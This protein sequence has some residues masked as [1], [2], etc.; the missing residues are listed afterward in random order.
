VAARIREFVSGLR[1]RHPDVYKAARDYAEK[2]GIAVADLQAA[3]I[4][5]YLASDEEGKEVLES[6]MEERA[7]SGGGKGTDV[8][9][10]VDMFVKMSEGITKMFNA[11]NDM[12]NAVS[13]SA[14][15][16][17]IEAITTAVDKIKTKGA[18]KGSGSLEDKIAGAFV[19]GLIKRVA[20]GAVSTSKRTKETGT[21][22][23]EKVEEEP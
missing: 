8:T 3:A 20:G 10:A 18:E 22:T 13:I 11:V 17:D 5:S 1:R 19:D 12:K 6:A 23:I 2:R 21:G 9:A 4:S 16:S 14:V 15:V 7:K